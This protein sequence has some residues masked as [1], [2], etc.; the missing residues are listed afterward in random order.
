[1]LAAQALRFLFR[2]GREE[3]PA[4]VAEHR[5]LPPGSVDHRRVMVGSY[6]SV[7]H[8]EEG[9]AEMANR[10]GGLAPDWRSRAPKPTVN[11]VVAATIF[12]ARV[13]APGKISGA[14]MN[15]HDNRVMAPGEPGYA[16]GGAKGSD[17]KQ[18]PPTMTTSPDAPLNEV[19]FN[20]RKIR[21][22]APQDANTT[23]MGYWRDNKSG[24]QNHVVDAGNIYHDRR[25]AIRAG[26]NRGESAIW[27]NQK[28]DEVR[29]DGK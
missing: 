29:L 7:I 6:R 17:G 1:M 22:S 19:L 15:V 20:A 8:R 21:K 25:K 11:P 2:L 3:R 28:V 18:V 10:R 16:V 12:S 14:T 13:N 26:V 23:T 4:R 9:K 5:E 24:E 27:D